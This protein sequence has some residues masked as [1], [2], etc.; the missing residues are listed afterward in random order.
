MGGLGGP[1]GERAHELLS[2]DKTREKVQGEEA[3]TDVT[4]PLLQMGEDGGL[5]Q[6]PSAVHSNVKHTVHGISTRELRR[7]DTRALECGTA[8]WWLLVV[9][10][11]VQQAHRWGGRAEA[12]GVA[13]SERIQAEQVQARAHEAFAAVL[14][15]S[16]SLLLAVLL[17]EEAG[18]NA[19]ALRHGR[20]L[21]A[22]QAAHG[23][24]AALLQSSVPLPL[25]RSALQALPR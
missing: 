25:V 9:A 14:R 12:L 24:M 15:P 6:T 7:S 2:E 8:R 11:L 21:E 19:L 10:D 1:N 17:P 5:G 20:V 3:R 18:E 23:L 22:H 13:D 4:E 16:I